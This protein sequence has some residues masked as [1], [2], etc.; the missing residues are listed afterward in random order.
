MKE[1]LIVSLAFD[2]KEC[3]WDLEFSD[4]IARSLNL[5]KCSTIQ[6]ESKIIHQLLE[7]GW[8]FHSAVAFPFQ[9]TSEDDD[10]YDKIFHSYVRKYLYFFR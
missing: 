8:S 3:N 4:K 9:T 10:V 7:E 1:N 5:S 2:M 6:A